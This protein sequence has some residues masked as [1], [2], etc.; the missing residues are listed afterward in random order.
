[1]AVQMGKL[2]K[3][4]EVGGLD[5]EVIFSGYRGYLDI[6][7]EL[8]TATN[9]NDGDNYTFKNTYKVLRVN[10]NNQNRGV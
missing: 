5:K 6:N 8:L 4:I 7:K 10:N 3:K 1:M 9:G 2:C